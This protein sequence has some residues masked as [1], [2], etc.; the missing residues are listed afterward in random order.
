MALA[1][2]L[3]PLSTLHESAVF[4]FIGRGAKDLG[5]LS[6]AL[7]PT[8]ILFAYLPVRIHAFADDPG[9]RANRVWQWI[10]TGWLILLSLLG[11]L[12]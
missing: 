9:D 4:S 7:V 5:P 8:T 2:T 12:S 3:V 11:S 10:T 6:L 1:A